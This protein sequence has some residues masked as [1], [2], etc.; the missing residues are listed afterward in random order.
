MV[1]SPKREELK[2][3]IVRDWCVVMLVEGTDREENERA[4]KAILRASQ[5]IVGAVTETGMR[6]K[7]KP[8]LMRLS[9]Q[10]ERI[11]L[12]SLGLPEPDRREPSAVVLFGR[13]QRIGPVLEGKEIDESSMLSLLYSLGKAC[14]CTTD[15][16]L[17]SGPQIPLRW[18][19][20]V[21]E[22]VCRELG[23]DPD[24][25]LVRSALAMLGVFAE[26]PNAC[27]QGAGSQAVMGYTESPANEPEGEEAPTIAL[28]VSPGEHGALNVQRSTPNALRL[29]LITLGFI[30]LSVGIGTIFL[31][32]RR[33]R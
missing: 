17:L 29:V 7:R 26:N 24:N 21:Q 14:A 4:E 9:P 10:E 18:G 32:M 15:P 5:Q 12:W 1:S 6:V 2:R 19:D 8:Y 28:P 23:F 33:R 31:W 20:E 13:G 27:V 25:P 16:K 3:H 30:F 22:E 11:L